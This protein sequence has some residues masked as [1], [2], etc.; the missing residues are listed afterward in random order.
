MAT[1]IR[2]AVPSDV[3]SLDVIRQQAMEADLTGRYPRSDFADLIATPDARLQDWVQSPEI[4]VLVGETD[5]TP[6]GYGVY[7]EPSDCILA[8]Y[9]APAYQGEGCAKAL[10]ERIEQHAR[11][12]NNDR[13]QITVPKPSVGFFLNRGFERQRTTDKNGL[14]MIVCTK[15]LK[16]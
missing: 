13:L 12:A 5:I 3:P 8:L 9:T 6:I 4:L 2:E 11:N 1:N 7:E 14:S 15:R 10:L 16:K